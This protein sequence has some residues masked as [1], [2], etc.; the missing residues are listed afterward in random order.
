MEKLSGLVL[1]VYD[2]ADGEVMKALYPERS[3]VPD[4]VK[5]AQRLTPDQLDRLPEDVF[6]LVLE[7]DGVELRKYACADAGNTRLAIDYF[8]HNGYKL[9]PEAQKVAAAN[10]VTACGWYDDLEPPEELEKVAI[11]IGMLAAPLILPGAIKDAKAG[12]QAT[13]GAGGRVMTPAQIKQR[14]MQM[15]MGGAR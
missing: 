8:L 14:K 13:K 4:M 9:P 15:M 1:D 6:A 2:D 10:L 7:D 11:G 5:T 3:S 12:H